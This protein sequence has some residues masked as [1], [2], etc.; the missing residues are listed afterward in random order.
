MDCGHGPAYRDKKQIKPMLHEGDRLDEDTRE[1][2]Y[3]SYLVAMR[4]SR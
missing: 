4:A 2:N 3:S 1:K